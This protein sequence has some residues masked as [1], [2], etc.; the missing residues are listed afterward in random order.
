MSK[1]E[2]L[3]KENKRLNEMLEP[4]QSIKLKYISKG[5]KVK[6]IAWGKD[7]RKWSTEKKLEYSEALASAMNEACDLIQQERNALIIRNRELEKVV[8]ELS[9]AAD[10]LRQANITNI[11]QTN[12]EKQQLIGRIRELEAEI[13]QYNAEVETS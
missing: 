3:E 7:Y 4:F 8:G 11:T 12:A 2:E 6:M 5:G 1:I 10:D 13:K 9:R